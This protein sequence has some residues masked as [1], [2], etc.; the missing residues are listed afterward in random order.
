MR[1]AYEIPI[2]QTTVLGS[3]TAYTSASLCTGSL[4]RRYVDD[5]NLYYLKPIDITYNRMFDNLG[6]ALNAKYIS[7]IP[8]S[9]DVDYLFLNH[10][11]TVAQ[12]TNMSMIMGKYTK[13]TNSFENLGRILINPVYAPGIPNRTANSITAYLYRYSSGSV[14]VNSTG[15]TGSSTNWATNRIFQGSRIGFGTTSSANVTQWYDI[16][17]VPTETNFEL[18]TAAITNY[19]PGT[20]YVI[21]E[22]KLFIPTLHASLPVNG[23]VVV[24]GLNES[25][26]TA[27]GTVVNSYTGSAQDRQRG[28]YRMSDVGSGSLMQNPYV[29]ELEPPTSP[30]NQNGYLLAA[31]TAATQIQY[32]KF[33]VLY[34]V[35]QSN[36]I[37][38]GSISESFQARTDFFTPVA[39]PQISLKIA[40]TKHGPGS[41]SLSLYTIGSGVYGTTA[42]RIYRTPLASITSGSTSFIAD[43]CLEVPPGSSETRTISGFATVDYSPQSDRFYLQGATTAPFNIMTAAQYNTTTDQLERQVLTNINA[44][45][46]TT[47]TPATPTFI[48]N[49]TRPNYTI[50]GDMMYVVTGTG[51]S[52]TYVVYNVPVGADY[53]GA[54]T[55]KQ[56]VSFPVINT[57]GAL[58]YYN[59]YPKL[60]KFLGTDSLGVTPERV[61]LYYRTSGIGNDSGTWLDV[62]ENG[63]MSQITIGNEIQFALAWDVLGL[64]AAPNR[65]YGLVFTYEDGS[66]DIHYQP[67]IAESDIANNIFAWRQTQLWGSNIPNLRIRLY[68]DDTNFLII[69]DDTITESQGTFEYSSD[70]GST[71]NPWDDTQDTIGNYIRYTATSL[72]ANTRI[73]ALLTLAL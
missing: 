11:G 51:A 52:G 7:A 47:S 20:P 2:T 41:G 43:S 58:A 49:G 68:N 29:M 30:T 66:Q 67:S 61:K 63:D 35:S 22:L 16:S 62:P 21:E 64:L 32:F 12:G 10:P 9:T 39:S 25:T 69:E 57:A 17:T 36:M 55:S 71:W 54:T 23:V 59:V 6:Y 40:T 42:G 3:T 34:P 19:A 24:N 44:V 65:V 28:F 48:I 45:N 18:A 13:S 14:E 5:D 60:S 26:F 72:P 27:A 31:N 53:K 8:W 37:W 15:V 56:W 33:N 4:I 46:K 1:A 38:T 70:N 73:R 50:N